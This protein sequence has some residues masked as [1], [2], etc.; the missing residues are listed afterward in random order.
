MIIHPGK[1]AYYYRTNIP[2][3]FKLHRCRSCFFRHY[4]TAVVEVHSK[5]CGKGEPVTSQPPAATTPDSAYGSHME[6]DTPPAQ[7]PPTSVS[8]SRSS[9]ALDGYKRGELVKDTVLIPAGATVGV[10]ARA[11]KEL[12]LCI[13]TGAH[14]DSEVHP[15]PQ[16]AADLSKHEFTGGLAQLSLESEAIRQAEDNREAELSLVHTRENLERQRLIIDELRRELAA[17]ESPITFYSGVTHDVVAVAL[18][19]RLG[20]HSSEHIYRMVLAQLPLLGEYN[21]VE[22]GNEFGSLVVQPETRNMA[23]AHLKPDKKLKPDG[24]PYVGA[25]YATAAGPWIL[26]GRIWLNRAVSNASVL[27]AHKEHSALVISA[28]FVP[29]P[30]WNLGEQ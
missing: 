14:T 23:T 30:R 28:T 4:R 20:L 19:A 27:L 15:R 29:P 17:P 16:D 10:G 24:H 22:D 7:K 2:P 3:F 21:I 18:I 11:K 1:T 12:K 9:P 26:M 6:L 8:S 13:T 5:D 25:L